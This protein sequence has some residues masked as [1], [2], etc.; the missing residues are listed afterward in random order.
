MKNTA[1]TITA[2]PSGLLSFETNGNSEFTSTKTII[3]N[4]VDIV[5]DLDI[6]GIITGANVFGGANSNA[7]IHEQGNDSNG[8]V[9][10]D[11]GAPK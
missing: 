5:G 4:D 3:N 11:T 10:Q 7:H 1:I 8:D 2:N 6:T 9:E